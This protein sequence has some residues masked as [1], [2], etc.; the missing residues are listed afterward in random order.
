M[1]KQRHIEWVTHTCLSGLA[2]DALGFALY[3]AAWAGASA[4]TLSTT[5]VATA[6][7]VSVVGLDALGRGWGW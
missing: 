7:A 2:V 1:A 6:P 5:P 3:D 4:G